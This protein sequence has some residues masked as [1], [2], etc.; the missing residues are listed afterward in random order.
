MTTLDLS[1]AAPGNAIVV[2]ANGTD[3]E[4]SSSAPGGELAE[5]ADV[6]LTGVAAGDTLITIDGA[7]WT[8]S[9][10]SIIEGSFGDGDTLI[11][12]E[13]AEAYVPV[14]AVVGVNHGSNAATARP[15]GALFVWWKGSVEPENAINGDQWYD[16]TG[17]A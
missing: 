12:E 17:D 13:A 11:Y 4:A 10:A 6:D 2:S 5:L 3:L 8:R 16:T 9:P 15:S 7:T 14:A 1:G